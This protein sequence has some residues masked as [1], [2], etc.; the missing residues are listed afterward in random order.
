MAGLDEDQ[1]SVAG[2]GSV[3][4]IKGRGGYHL[5]I[6]A[7]DSAWEQELTDWWNGEGDY[8]PVTSHPED[9]PQVEWC[10]ANMQWFKLAWY[11]ADGEISRAHSSVGIGIKLRSRDDA[12][13]CKMKF[14]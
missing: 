6:P 13:A 4:T 9:C 2:G 14:S 3:K 10:D 8:E 11:D 7:Q 12:L 1:G 5:A